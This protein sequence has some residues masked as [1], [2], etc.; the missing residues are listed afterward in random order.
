MPAPDAAGC[1]STTPSGAN[2]KVF[3]EQY[4]DMA[5]KGEWYDAGSRG[6]KTA[7]RN[8]Y[9]T[10]SA[11]VAVAAAATPTTTIIT[12]TTTATKRW[13]AICMHVVDRRVEEHVRKRALS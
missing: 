10:I 11:H 4:G 1:P 3:R 13:H 7:V 9:A 6:L 12:T 5:G 8:P 2:I